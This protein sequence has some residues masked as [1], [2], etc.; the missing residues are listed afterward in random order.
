ML[1]SLAYL[2]QL[3]T[4]TYQVFVSMNVWSIFSADYFLF[5]F[6]FGITSNNQAWEYTK[7]Y[8]GRFAEAWLEQLVLH[9][10][11]LALLAFK[12]N[13]ESRA[14]AKKAR[15][16]MRRGGVIKSIGDDFDD[17]DD[18]DDDDDEMDDV[19]DDD[20]DDDDFTSEL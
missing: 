1:C 12:I 20:D 3:C 7:L 10:H 11:D 18:D 15:E 19:D 5:A 6:P 16:S 13:A 17:F 14:P 9:R 8:L 2:G 4:A